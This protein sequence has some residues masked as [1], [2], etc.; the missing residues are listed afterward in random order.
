MWECS[1]FAV[2]RGSEGNVYFVFRKWGRGLYYCI[3]KVLGCVR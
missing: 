2:E 3:L 1:E